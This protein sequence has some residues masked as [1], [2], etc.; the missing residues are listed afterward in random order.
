MRYRGLAPGATTDGKSPFRLRRKSNVFQGSP[1]TKTAFE[2][3]A[4]DHPT[5]KCDVQEANASRY[6][7]PQFVD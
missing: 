2:V 5:K 1:F 6:E 7:R 3:H 4:V